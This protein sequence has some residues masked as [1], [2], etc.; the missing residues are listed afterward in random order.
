[1]TTS[2]TVTTTWTAL[3]TGDCYLQKTGTGDIY[4]A[5]SAVAPTDFS[6]AH[7]INTSAI[8]KFDAPTTGSIYVACP[9]G[10]VQAALTE[11]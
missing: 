7:L 5:Y 8:Q 1:M 6:A 10:I 4:L 3:T 9:R 2:I 11:L